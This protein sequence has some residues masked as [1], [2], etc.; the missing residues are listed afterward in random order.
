MHEERDRQTARSRTGA[1]PLASRFWIVVFMV[2][3]SGTM[4]IQGLCQALPEGDPKALTSFEVTTF[5]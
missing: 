4:I 5:F 2:N 3:T 1:K